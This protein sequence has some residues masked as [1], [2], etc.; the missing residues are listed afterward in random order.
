[1][2][3]ERNSDGLHWNIVEMVKNGHFF[4]RVWQQLDS[5]FTQLPG[6]ALEKERKNINLEETKLS[7]EK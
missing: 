7:S 3:K 1:M 6:V 2:K 4:I 5:V